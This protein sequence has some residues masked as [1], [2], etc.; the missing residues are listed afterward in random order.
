MESTSTFDKD[1]H[2]DLGGWVHRAGGGGG[3]VTF[4]VWVEGGGAGGVT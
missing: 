4:C 2:G 1:S 3:G